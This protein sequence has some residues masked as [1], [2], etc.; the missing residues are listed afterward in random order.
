[1]SKK[2]RNTQTK[3]A[4]KEPNRI[5]HD[6]TQS[7]YMPRDTTIHDLAEGEDYDDTKYSGPT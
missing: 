2:K 4:V 1:M 7:D 5:N 6:A 3:A